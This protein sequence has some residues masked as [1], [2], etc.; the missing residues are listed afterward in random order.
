MGCHC[1]TKGLQIDADIYATVITTLLAADDQL[2]EAQ[3]SRFVTALQE[4]QLSTSDV[5]R[6]GFFKS[7]RRSGLEHG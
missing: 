5:D 6:H 4:A 2:T 7:H 1:S 3:Q